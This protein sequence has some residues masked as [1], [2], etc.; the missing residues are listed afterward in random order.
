MYTPTYNFTIQLQTIWNPINTFYVPRLCST[1][2]WWWLF[3]SR[4]MSPRSWTT[5]F[6][7]TCW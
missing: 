6:L 2:A 3:Y 5:T 1:L 4:N 7:Q